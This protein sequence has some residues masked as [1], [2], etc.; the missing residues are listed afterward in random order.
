MGQ[1]TG[2]TRATPPIEA[3]PRPSQDTL[4]KSQRRGYDAH[5][6][7]NSNPPNEETDS[8][9]Q[10]WCVQLLYSVA[11]TLAV[12]VSITL[13]SP[14]PLRI[15]G[16]PLPGCSLW[17]VHGGR[18]V[19]QDSCPCPRL[20][21]TC[22]DRPSM[23]PSARPR[24]GA[25]RHG[26]PI[27]LQRLCAPRSAERFQVGLGGCYSRRDAKYCRRTSR[28]CTQS[29]FQLY[30]PRLQQTENRRRGAGWRRA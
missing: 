6:I 15:H 19:S 16:A 2:Q 23:G 8:R 5:G 17:C 25:D 24:V 1:T 27:A 9:V 28:R 26:V 21:I 3:C 30:V 29:H 12:S 4:I 22:C 18:C 11:V 20:C 10:S 14:S 7:S 13:A